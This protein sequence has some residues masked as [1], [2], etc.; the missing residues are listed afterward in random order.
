MHWIGPYGFTTTDARRTFA[1]IAELWRMYVHGLADVPP[2]ATDQAGRVVERL[3]GST[4]ERVDPSPDDGG[5]PTDALVAVGAAADR[6]IATG[7]WDTTFT[8]G[9]LAA[10]WTGMRAIGDELRA[11]GCVAVSGHGAVAQLN[12]SAGGVPKMPVGVA[13]VD[14]SGVIGDAQRSRQHHGRPW[15][16]LCLWGL[17]VIEGFADAGHPIRPGAAG[18][19]VTITGLD[20]AEVRPGSRLRIGSVECEVSSYS[21]PCSKNARWFVDGEFRRMHHTAG[22]VSRVYA[23]VLQPGRIVSGDAVTLES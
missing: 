2:A 12:T 4:G 6:C 3:A 8:T 15:Q 5:D 16:A 9:E 1:G 20:W 21:L 23:T 11:A 17:E 7:E 18:E 10:T 14:W 19:N 13:E 22:P